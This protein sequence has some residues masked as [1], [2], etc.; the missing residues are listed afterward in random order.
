MA[1]V[2]APPAG[3]AQWVKG[4]EQ[5]RRRERRKD[6]DVFDMLGPFGGFH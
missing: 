5:G 4:G 1:R 2:R 6:M 3:G